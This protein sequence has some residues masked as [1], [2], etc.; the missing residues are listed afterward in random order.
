VKFT[1]LVVEIRSRL[2]G[3]TG[4]YSEG[5]ASIAAVIKQAGHEFE[6]LHITRPTEARLLA[7]R[8]RATAPDVVGFSCM[9]HNFA[10]M[11]TF[12]GEIKAALPRTPTVLG[13]VHAILN[14]EESIRVEGLDAVCVGEGEAVVLPL[15]E[16]IERGE[17]FDDLEGLWVRS[18]ETIHRNAPRP[19]ITDLDSLPAPDRTVFDIERLVS[20]REGVI[21]AFASRGCPYACAFCSNA[22]LRARYPNPQQYLRY[23]SVG[24]VCQEIEDAARSFPGELRGIFFEDDILT[25][26]TNWLKEF[27][28]VY[29]RR[30]GIPFNCNLRADSVSTRVADLLQTAGCTSVAIGVE[31]GVEAIRAVVLGKK[32]ADSTFLTAF[33]RLAERGIRISTLSMVGLPGE[34]AAE[35]LQTVFFN[36]ESGTDRCMVSIFCPYP[37]TP[38]HERAVA[39]GILSDRQPDTYQEDTPL[40]QTSISASQVRFIHDFFKEMIFLLRF[41][42]SRVMLKRFLTRYVQRDGISMRVL[43]RLKRGARYLLAA[44]YLM[45]GRYLYNRQARVFRRAEPVTVLRADR[46]T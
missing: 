33:R 12:V 38:L 1:M 23:K 35:A 36:A 44:P 41:P 5:V 42:R 8:V 18:G 40:D 21:Y 9:T 27:A 15:L 24:R 30:V 19:L 14:P 39:E 13:G 11:R 37:G 22:A 29:P 16:R 31:S 2:P 4:H 34:S 43:S 7:Q 10:Y 6:L 26:N 17:S 3:F 45:F 46:D 32:I 20:T 28:E 25:L